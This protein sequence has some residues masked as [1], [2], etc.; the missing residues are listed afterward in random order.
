MIGLLIKNR[1]LS[2]FGAMVSKNKGGEV[3]RASRFKMIFTALLLVALAAFFT[4]SVTSMLLM[5][6]D[7]ILSIGGEWLYYAIISLV[8]LALTV[9]LSIFETKSELFECKDNELL[10]SMPIKPRDILIS[11]I[12][13]VLIYNYLI[14]A[15]V[16][17]PAIVIYGLCTHDIMGILGGILIYLL[18]VQLGVS[19]ASAIGFLVAKISKF[20]KDKTFITVIIAIVFLIAYFWGYSYLLE[21]LPTL[22]GGLTD[23]LDSL[24]TDAP[25]LAFIGS[26]AL[27]DPLATVCFVAV[28]AVVSLAA[29]F[30]ISHNYISLLTN[31]NKGTRVKYKEKNLVASSALLAVVKK[32]FFRF[33]SSATYILNAG[34]G[35]LM[36]IVIS[37]YALWNLDLLREFFAIT[38]DSFA[39]FVPIVAIIVMST[40]Y[41][42]SCALSL[43]GNAF[44]IIKSMPIG[45]RTVILGKVIP[46]MV[47]SIP[48]AIVTGVLLSIAS[49]IA[50]IYVIFAIL[51]PIVASV[52]FAFLG[53]SFNTLFPKFD[54]KSEAHV[55]KQSLSAVLT[56]F[57][58]MAISIAFVPLA[59]WLSSLAILPIYIFSIVLGIWVLL[60]AIFAVIALVPC[61]SKI[62]KMSV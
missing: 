9:V 11:R 4:Y 53:I 59:S 51:T 61:A 8:S 35:F 20:F 10:L 57:S 42:S 1:F 27:L 32:E 7:V 50:P 24:K 18:I 44:W 36:S 33:F 5:V 46:Q 21:G 34:I 39:P 45:A 38:G 40:G 52:A 54:Y 13:V 56:L 60:T 6:A 12:L 14:D 23:G 2:L 22:L 49:G 62:E 58:Q 16:M 41:M 19:L 43:E 17:I 29:L 31:A 47:I 25:A 26:I 3:K 15:I 48:V 37:V 28:T 55:V 30:F